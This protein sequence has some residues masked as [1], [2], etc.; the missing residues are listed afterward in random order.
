MR[1]TANDMCDDM[2]DV[3]VRLCY[4]SH[5]LALTHHSNRDDL[6]ISS[7]DSYKLPKYKHTF[8]FLTIKI[9]HIIARYG[10]E[11][12]N[13]VVKSVKCDFEVEL[14]IVIVRGRTADVLNS[15]PEAGQR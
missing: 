10:T 11:D 3:I 5:S 7:V 12:M 6:M 13:I 14:S 1:R 2:D 15:A 4:L 8:I 9:H